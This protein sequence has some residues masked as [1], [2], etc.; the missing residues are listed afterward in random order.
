[1]LAC[2]SL[3]QKEG[4]TGRQTNRERASEREGRGERVNLLPAP[5]ASSP[6]S[7]PVLL[8][9]PPRSAGPGFASP[10]PA[11]RPPDWWGGRPREQRSGGGGSS[12]KGGGGGG[13]NTRSEHLAGGRRAELTTAQPAR[14]DRGALGNTSAAAPGFPLQREG[15]WDEQGASASCPP[16]RERAWQP[17]LAGA[18]D[19]RQTPQPGARRGPKQKRR[20]AEGN[21]AEASRTKKALSPQRE[22]LAAPIETRQKGLSGTDRRWVTEGRNTERPLSLPMPQ[23]ASGGFPRRELNDPLGVCKITLREPKASAD[24]GVKSLR[25]GSSLQTNQF[26]ACK[27]HPP[28][29]RRRVRLHFIK[30]ATFQSGSGWLQHVFTLFNSVAGHGPQAS[31]F[32]PNRKNF[33]LHCRRFHLSIPLTPPHTHGTVLDIT[34]GNRSCWHWGLAVSCSL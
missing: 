29:P 9:H 7:R 26:C 31:Q 19:R 5:L 2:V 10:P 24:P 18:R 13:G 3:G 25:K 1:M 16:G 33:A 28:Q 21:V 6:A 12:R 15:A 4:E 22:S 23:N 20:R 17:R 32:K 30:K 14:S 34:R 27:F 11:S 8:A